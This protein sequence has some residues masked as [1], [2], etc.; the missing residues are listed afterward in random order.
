M[1][2]KLG[3]YLSPYPIYIFS[4]FIYRTKEKFKYYILRNEVHSNYLKKKILC[5][6]FE[7]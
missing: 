5:I 3:M 1:S 2:Q 6:Y 7:T 4:K